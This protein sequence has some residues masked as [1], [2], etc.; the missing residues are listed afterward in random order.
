[1]YFV[2]NCILYKGIVDIFSG[3]CGVKPKWEPRFIDSKEYTGGPNSIRQLASD[4]IL[5][6]GWHSFANIFVLMSVVES[7]LVRNRRAFSDGQEFTGS[8]II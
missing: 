7:T 2:R 4:L 1:M 3:Q 6:A 8:A 5:C